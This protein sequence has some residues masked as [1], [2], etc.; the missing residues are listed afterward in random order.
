MFKLFIDPVTLC[1]A[2]LAVFVMHH[3]SYECYCE[4]P[5]LKRPSSLHVTDLP[6]L[7]SCLRAG[8]SISSSFLSLLAPQRRQSDASVQMNS[9][10]SNLEP[11]LLKISEASDRVMKNQKESAGEY[12]AVHR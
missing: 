6:V 11:V 7:L 8:R 3:T 12:M 10:M 9:S 1:S 2:A 5:M 4:S